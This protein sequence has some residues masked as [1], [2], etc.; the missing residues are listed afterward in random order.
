MRKLG[1][2]GEEE[3]DKVRQELARANEL[4]SGLKMEIGVLQKRRVEMRQE[5]D[6][7]SA[8]IKHQRELELD[9]LVAQAEAAIAPLKAERQE[10]REQV[11]QVTR[12]K[13]RLDSELA[14][15]E[16]EIPAVRQTLGQVTREVEAARG[17]WQKIETSRIA[18][19]AQITKLTSSIQPLR[20][21][22]AILTGEVRANIAKRDEIEKE[23]VGLQNAHTIRTGEIKLE[24][25]SLERKRNELAT[26]LSAEAQALKDDRE[27]LAKWAET[28]AK[29]EKIVRAR[30]FK[31]SIA[32]EKI[33][34]NV[35]LLNL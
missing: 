4:L 6:E 8:E 24:M 15:V 16:G 25:A 28:L 10:L 19:T 9:D 13:I 17:E 22:L 30:E 11:A 31:V 18:I 20:E 7:E 2:E 3:R 5:I 26:R 29:Q 35:N 1:Q 23:L 33:A 12:E 34:A 32:E 14:G 21:E 27:Q